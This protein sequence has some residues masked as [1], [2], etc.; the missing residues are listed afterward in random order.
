MTQ[1]TNPLRAWFR[2]PAIYI[3]LP[4]QGQYW[5]DGSIEIPQNGELPV[6]PMTAVD[7]INYRTPDALF[8]GQA[9]VDV[10]Q[11]CVPAIKNAWVT[12]ALDITSILISIRIA[13]YGHDMEVTSTCPGCNDTSDYTLDMRIML[14]NIKRPNYDHIIKSGDLELFF[15]PMTYQQQTQ[16]GI[17][18]YETQR[19]IAASQDPNLPDDRKTQAMSEAMKR[20]GQATTRALTYTI[21]GIRSP[22]AFVDNPEHVMEFLSNCDRKLY[23]EVRDHAV[24]LRSGNEIQ[25]ARITCQA[26]QNQYDQEIELDLANFFVA[27][28]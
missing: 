28:S 3:R 13:S 2:Q 8:N 15:R 19:I 26:C 24:T 4:S 6:L 7:E 12:P 25:P 18:Q 9:V 20:I 10:I 5:P 16:I 1:N 23:N 21:A 17:D 11:S 14:D 22:S 27:A